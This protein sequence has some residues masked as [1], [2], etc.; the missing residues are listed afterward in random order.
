MIPISTLSISLVSHYPLDLGANAGASLRGALYEALAV[1]YDTG[2]TATKHDVESNP[3][4]WLMRLEAETTGGKDVPRPIA[5]R[6]PLQTQPDYQ[7]QFGISF[8]G[9]AQQLIPLVIS[10]LQGIQGIG[11]GRGRQPVTLGKVEWLDPLTR[12]TQ[13]IQG[14]LP[15]PISAQTYQRFSS[16]LVQDAL[17]VR[18]LTPTRIIR[19]DQLCHTPIFR[20]W[21]QRL[22]ERIRLLS[23]L[24][25]EAVWIPFRDLLAEADLITLTQDETRWQEGWTHNSREGVYRPMGGFIG[26]VSYSGDFTQLMPYIL[27]GQSI[28]VGKNTIKGSGWYEV[29]Y[30]WQ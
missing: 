21:F 1:M 15:T 28:Q 8:Y 29:S 9:K 4:A 23:E 5:I 16:M 17:T 25:A 26:Q 20:V 12:Q 13:P 18:F 24:Y 22:L 6:P 27:L 19:Q 7:T 2:A 11:V 3:V 30:R 14:E 10:A